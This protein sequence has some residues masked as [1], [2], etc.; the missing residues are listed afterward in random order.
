MRARRLLTAGMATAALAAAAGVA[1]AGAP[2]ASWVDTGTRALSLTGATSLGAAPTGTPVRLAVGLTPQ[3]KQ[4]IAPLIAAQSTPGN[5]SYGQFL[6]PAQ[7]VNQFAPSVGQ[8][9]AVAAYLSSQGL[10]NVQIAANRLQV[11]AEGTVGQAQSAFHTSI[12]LF[13]LG[14]H[15]VYANTAAA[16]VPTALSGAISA[17]L[18]LN[19]LPMNLPH[20]RAAAGTPNLTGFYP[21][22]FQ[23]VY[24]AAGTSTGSATSIAI[25]A[26]GNLTSTIK[27]LRVA[28]A[29]QAL[30]QVPVSVLPTGPASSDT[31]GADEWDL[32]SQTSTGVAQTVRHVYFY[33]AT[34]LSDSDLA[35]AI[36]S[37]AAQNIAQAGSASL[38]ECD[39]L[40]YAD[41][42]MLVDDMA[43]A[44]AAL[45]GQSFFAS[46]GDTGSSCAIAPTNGV[47]G[48]GAP[49]TEYPASG[50][51]TTGV[52]GT[53]LLAGADGSYQN[54]IAWN[55]GG[56]GA[57]V[58]EFP[59]IWTAN[60][61]PAY[62]ALGV[63]G[64]GRGVPDIAADADPNTGAL[65]Y[66]NGVP[67]QIGGTS[68]SSPLLLGA[69][70][71][72]ESGH[73]NRLGFASPK[74][75]GIYNAVNSAPTSRAAVPGF[76]DIVVGVNGIYAATPGYDFTTGLGTPDLKVLNSKLH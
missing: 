56:G 69:W 49:D 66:V 23:T 5:A 6:T 25:I 50:T 54:E 63:I 43:L 51:Y 40:A 65:I 76:H 2:P 11:T 36:N 4:Q 1:Q 34:S 74:L 67:T 8:A 16:Q 68:L 22:Q 57:S 42:S 24:D 35:R 46:S 28:E 55:A 17:V 29:K 64:A 38:G 3:H 45:Q 47:P 27:D 33:D 31:A 41:G 9:Q 20:K 7:F 21:K 30:P 37:F 52:G 72:L 75:Y 53:T 15:T 13:S 59:G 44:Q 73:A 39:A 18:G 71:R 10:R 26:E 19:D 70:A 60:A 58:L 62:P 48:S 12:G 32:D 61:N 14:G